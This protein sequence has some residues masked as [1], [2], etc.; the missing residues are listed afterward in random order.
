MLCDMYTSNQKGQLDI[1]ER[2]QRDLVQMRF[3][4]VKAIKKAIYTNLSVDLC[5]FPGPGCQKGGLSMWPMLA[6]RQDVVLRKRPVKLV[7]EDDDEGERG[8][9][10]GEWEMGEECVINHDYIQINMSIKVAARTVLGS[11]DWGFLPSS[12]PRPQA[13]DVERF[14]TDLQ[15]VRVVAKK[16]GA[17]GKELHTL[18]GGGGGGGGSDQI[19]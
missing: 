1:I 10:E 19:N 7:L 3:K 8:E 13:H 12:H 15:S 6:F 16:R 5:G 14:L 11:V 4:S 2:D 9:G 18:D 17:D